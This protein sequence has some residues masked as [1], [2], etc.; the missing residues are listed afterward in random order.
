MTFVRMVAQPESFLDRFYRKSTLPRMIWRTQTAV[1]TAIVCAG[2]LAG[3]TA[4]MR[5][6]EIATASFA[7]IDNDFEDEILMTNH[8]HHEYKPVNDPEDVLFI[9]VR[10]HL[11]NGVSRANLCQPQTQ[12]LMSCL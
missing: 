8:N 2:L 7:D 10:N 5:D 6:G 12:L 9:L 11:H 4:P 3:C 1:A